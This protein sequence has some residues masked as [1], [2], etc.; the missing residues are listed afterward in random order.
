M[1]AEEVVEKILAEAKAEAEKI[2][3]LAE[4]KEA[5][6]Q[7]KLDEQL[8]E[9]GEQTEALAGQAGEDEKAHLLAA[10]RMD[11]AKQLLAEKREIL[12]EVF[13]QARRQLESLPDEQYRGLMA[14]LMLDV[15]ETGDE[16]VVIGRNE[17][18]INGELIGRVNQQ[19]SSAGK[20]NLRL[21][22]RR[23]DIGAGFILKRGKI[24][25]NVSVDVLI[26]QAREAL[27]IELAKKL[28]A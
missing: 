23:E 8:R 14:K 21:S 19:L 28:F 24:K 2:K 6:E 1:G 3:N 15:V 11:V 5:A 20:G 26:A 12:D 16:E 18:R 9:Y 10:A 22:E 25:T 4:E 27:E 17:G 13:E 7:A